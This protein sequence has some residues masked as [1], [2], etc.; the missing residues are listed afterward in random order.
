MAT[1]SYRL[2][3]EI[4]LLEPVEEDKAERLKCCFS[5]GVIELEYVNGTEH[6]IFIELETDFIEYMLWN[7]K[8]V[9]C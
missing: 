4:T 1:A 3:P 8:Y 9:D 6:F 5:Q 2:L 7:M